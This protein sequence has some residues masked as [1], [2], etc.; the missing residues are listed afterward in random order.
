MDTSEENRVSA[1]AAGGLPQ[2]LWSAAGTGL[3][4]MGAVQLVLS[5]L[6]PGG[7]P[8]PVRVVV[9]LAAGLLSALAVYPSRKRADDARRLAQQSAA[10][11]AAQSAE[12]QQA[13]LILGRAS[14][15]TILG[16]SRALDR[17]EQEAEGHA[18]RLAD[19]AVRMAR[20]AGL[21]E[22]QL[23]HVRRGALLHDV[24]KLAIPDAILLKPGPLDDAEWEVMRRHPQDGYD[25]LVANALLAPALDIPLYHHEKWDGTGYPRALRGEDIP[26]TARLFAVADVWDALCSTR[27]YRVA[28]PPDTARQLIQAL[29]GEH[30]D[31]KAVEIFLSLSDV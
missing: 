10:A 13:N 19:V 24:G 21:D 30:F 7:D 23:Q 25:M 11:A 6:L 17:R 3:L 14:D 20:A 8:W 26:L 16:W 15:A 28:W 18:E 31:P 9:V 22:S 12:L 4:G 2:T 5:L 29:A 27:P 1:G